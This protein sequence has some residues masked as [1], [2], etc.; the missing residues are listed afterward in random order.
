MS[1]DYNYF[2]EWGEIELTSTAGVHRVG[3]PVYVL[4]L[5]LPWFDA[6]SVFALATA[7]ADVPRPLKNVYN[8]IRARPDSKRL[9]LA[10]RKRLGTCKDH[11]II[12]DWPDAL[13][14]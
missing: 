7:F 13:A 2:I 14:L 10:Y 6:E 3:K 1:K 5:V 11:P 8:W 12:L 9:I 4:D